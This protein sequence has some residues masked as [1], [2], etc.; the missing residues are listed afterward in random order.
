MLKICKACGVL[1]EHASGSA[2]TCNKCI[3]HGYKWCSGCGNVLPITSFSKNVASTHS[4]C[5]TC[6][7]KKVLEHYH[8]R[9]NTDQEYHERI[10]SQNRK[11]HKERYANDETYRAMERQRSR[12]REA[13]KV[14][15]GYITP[16]EWQSILNEFGNS[17]AYCGATKDITMDHIVPLSAGGT[18]TVKN[19]VPACRRCNCSKGAKN[20][21]K[22]Y[23]AQAFFNK[24]RLLKILGGDEKCKMA[25]SL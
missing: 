18:N 17:C 3:S 16:K 14:S 15:T 6:R 19:I 24:E 7:G 11:W 20:V 21:T 1:S 25:K 13:G 22:W 5:N 2:T 10:R 23:T 12:L 4:R 9:Y 8:K